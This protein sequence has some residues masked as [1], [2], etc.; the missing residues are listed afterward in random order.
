MG[1]DM[2]ATSHAALI[3]LFAPLPLPDSLTVMFTSGCLPM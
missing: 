2:V 1:R 3:R